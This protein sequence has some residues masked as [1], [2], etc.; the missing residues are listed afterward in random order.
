MFGGAIIL[1]VILFIKILLSS[2]NSMIPDLVLLQ[3]LMSL[4]GK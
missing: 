4:L 3:S 2:M 1:Q